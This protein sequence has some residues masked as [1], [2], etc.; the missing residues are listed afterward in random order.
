MLRN[1]PRLDRAPAIPAEALDPHW[2]DPPDMALAEQILAHRVPLLGLGPVDLGPEIHWR[3]DYVHGK[4]SGLSY[5]RNIPYLDF[6]RVGDHKNIWELNRHQHLVVLA[7]AFRA[8]R[9]P[10]YLEE[11]RKQIESWMEQNPF[12]RGI[13]WA[14]A[15]EVAFR[16]LS[17]MAVLHLA[18][19]KLDGA[20]L[21][22]WT[23]SLFQHGCYLEQNLSVYFSPNTHL[24]GEAVVLHA[25]GSFLTDL[26]RASRW[27]ELGGR[28]VIEQ[29]DRQVR[30]DGSHFEQSSYYHLYAL[31]MF[32]LYSRVAREVPDWYRGKLAR[33]AEFLDALV[34]TEGILPF[35]GDEDGGRL[36]HPYGDRRKFA[37]DTLR[38]C[39]LRQNGAPYGS[40]WFPDAGLAVM[41]SEAA[42]II[43][44]AGPF[45]S[46]TAG[47]SHADT[48]SIVAFRNGE[49]LLIDPGTFTYVADPAARDRYRS[50][51]SHNTIAIRGV[52]QATPQG[53]F[54]WTNPPPVELLHW[55]STGRGDVLDA[56][57]Q[58]SGFTH[59]RTV[60]L[61]KPDV[62]LVV[63]RVTGPPGEWTVEQRWLCP[64]ECGTPF[65]ATIPVCQTEGGERS[66]ALG[67]S[68][69]GKRWVARLRGSLPL[70]FAAAIALGRSAPVPTICGED[71]LVA[72]EYDGCA[73]RL[74]NNGPPEL[75][76]SAPG[77]LDGQ[78]EQPTESDTRTSTALKSLREPAQN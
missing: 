17:W 32:L 66:T 55:N 40:Q 36:F 73:I 28:L 47:H 44:D 25:L 65:L 24:L 49:E 9:K 50:V 57:C 5:F 64:E 78:P 74:P 33:M 37:L 22:S 18:G 23:E 69:P 42:H 68:Q 53:P 54:R 72:V 43:V 35:L 6:E 45:G 75:I 59:R 26:P 20:F 13:N 76:G 7:Q 8:A 38:A 21:K 63:D 52:E 4:E 27:R 3:R 10:E 11:I 51:A 70:T 71:G 19:S 31:D 16:A 48:L 41:R 61:Q 56:R 29:M 39:G 60:V 15:L 30:D 12:E 46:G 67:S 1:P 58:Y 77:R 34:S 2:L 62:L 14:S